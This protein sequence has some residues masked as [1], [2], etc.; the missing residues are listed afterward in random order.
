MLQPHHQTGIFRNGRPVIQDLP[1]P[2]AAQ[3]VRAKDM[4]EGDEGDPEESADNTEILWN[5]VFK[6]YLLSPI[7]Q[8]WGGVINQESTLID[9]LPQRG[10]MFGQEPWSLN[11][12]EDVES[13]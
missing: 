7:W 8:A 5:T 10:D 9:S 2:V 4:A 1:A 11:E 13:R 3:K 6:S 12:H